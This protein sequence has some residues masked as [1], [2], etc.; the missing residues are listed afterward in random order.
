MGFKVKKGNVEVGS[1]GLSTPNPTLP[2]NLHVPHAG[3]E[4]ETSHNAK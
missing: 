4:E 1:M 2:L 3:V